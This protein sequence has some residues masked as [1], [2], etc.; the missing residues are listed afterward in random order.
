MDLETQ[1]ALAA[2]LDRK[3]RDKF[4]VDWLVDE[5]DVPKWK[6]K[7]IVKLVLAPLMSL[8]GKIAGRGVAKIHEVLK[9]RFSD[10]DEVSTRFA[11]LLLIKLECDRTKKKYSKECLK[12]PKGEDPEN[13]EKLN[14]Q[15]KVWIKH[16]QELE[17]ISLSLDDMKAQVRLH[18]DTPRLD[19]NTAPSR[20][21]RPYNTFIPLIGRDIEK[22]NLNAWLNEEKGF[23]WKI[24]IGEGGIGKTRL[25]QEFAQD[26]IKAEWDSGFLDHVHLDSL[27]NHGNFSN[28]VPLID[29]LIIVDYAATK[30]ESLKKLLHQCACVQRNEKEESAKLRLLFLERHANKD[31][32]WVEELQKT[33]E[34]ALKDEIC[35][36]LHD[37]VKLEPPQQQEDNKTMLSL[38]Q[39]TLTRWVKLTGEVAPELPELSKEDFYQ[40]RNNTEG[41]PLYL[42]MAALHACEIKS[43]GEIARW[44]RATLLQDAVKRERDYIGKHCSSAPQN[45]VERLA[46][47]LYFV[48][49]IP[50]NH[51]GLL[52]VV[53]AEA[54]ACGHDQTETAEMV[55]ILTRLFQD[56]ESKE[57]AIALEPI[58][59]DLIGAAFSATVLQEQ[60]NQ[61][62]T[63]G[64]A[65]W[66]GGGTAWANLLRS[67]QD[68]Y[69]VGT[70][71]QETWLPSLLAE[72]SQEEL[73]GV[74]GLLPNLTVALRFFAVILYEVLLSQSEDEVEQALIHNN[75]G[76]SYGRS[77]RREEALDASLKAINIYERLSN[78]NPDDFEPALASSLNNLGLCYGELGQR[79]AALIASLKA[80]NIYERLSNKNPDSFEP[81]LAMSLNNLGMYYGKLG[82]RGGSP[83]CVS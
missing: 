57:R 54:D 83:R 77:G 15:T 61:K 76:N 64:R 56:D 78:K 59:P 3:D 36:A 2:F 7:G 73:W 33:G 52:E 5:N 35:D 55:D 47:L 14:E 79:E 13:W 10:Y 70:F 63:L 26:S 24:I 82:R 25:A 44:N 48:G 65:I 37:I 18:I 30:Q 45:L 53:R 4:I 20:W 80:M 42:Q 6:A 28:W 66:L 21:L 8:A 50:G 29:T 38:L 12:P 60:G 39:A 22:D 72:R 31:Q 32:G 68:L 46:A 62:E 17:L 71:E 40:L 16:L 9:N 75:L 49:R 41:R 11:D 34:R 58:Q 81:D 69:G 51:S 43:A 1:N 27:V 23:S 19:K 74:A 67:A